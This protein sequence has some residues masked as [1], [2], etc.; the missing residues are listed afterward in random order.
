MKVLTDRD[1]GDEVMQPL[2]VI[3]WRMDRLIEAGYPA[4]SAM[5]LRLCRPT[6]IRHSRRRRNI[7]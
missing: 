5:R 2:S 6:S 1:P 4:L 7:A 3:A